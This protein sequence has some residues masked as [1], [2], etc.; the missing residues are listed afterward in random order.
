MRMSPRVNLLTFALFHEE[1]Q[2]K[3]KRPEKRQQKKEQIKEGKDQGT[4]VNH[5]MTQKVQSLMRGCADETIKGNF[6]ASL[7]LKL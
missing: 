6:S 4:G 3:Q 7:K 5:I 1:G 2:Q